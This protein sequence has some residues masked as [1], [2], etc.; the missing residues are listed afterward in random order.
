MI[1]TVLNKSTIQ[2][3]K[4]PKVDLLIKSLLYTT[5]LHCCFYLSIPLWGILDR[6]HVSGEVGRQVIRIY[7]TKTV[8][9][10]ETID[11]YRSIDST[12]TTDG[13]VRNESS[14]VLN[15]LF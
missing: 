10:A 2:Q 13:K 12:A 5:K 6:H 3:K 11:S 7:S 8:V 14:I 15:R 4:K 9:A 1:T